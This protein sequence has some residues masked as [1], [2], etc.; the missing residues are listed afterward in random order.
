[1]VDIFVSYSS[2][3]LDRVLPLVAA[4]EAEGWNVWWDRELVTGDS[5]D[6]E[7]ENALEVA[8][9]IVVV[10]SQESINSRWVRAEAN[11]G[12]ERRI[13]IPVLIDPVRPPLVF[14]SSQTAN[15][16]GWPAESGQIEM[17]IAAINDLP[18]Q[19][20]KEFQPSASTVPTKP[21]IAVLPFTNLSG[22][23]ENEYFSDG[24]TE[25]ILNGLSRSREIIVKARTS[26]FQFKGQNVDVREIAQRLGVTH[27]VE[28]SVRR[29]GDQV[30]V[31]AQ[32]IDARRDDHVWS[33][34]YT[35][36]LT[37]VFA[38]QDE[39]AAS[40]LAA[41][42]LHLPS[43]RTQTM[44]VANIE[45]YSLYL[46]GKHFRN[47]QQF[48]NALAALEEAIRLEPNF[49]QVYLEVIRVHQLRFMYQQ[50]SSKE[51][52]MV[53]EAL[54]ARAKELDPNQPML[55]NGDV[56][57]CF[58]T[59]R[60]YQRALSEYD[61]IARK[62]PNEMLIIG[63]YALALR[64][65]GQMDLAIACQHQV[66]KL[67]PINP[68]AHSIL[69]SY[70]LNAGR[71]DEARER[72][73]LAESLGIRSPMQLAL[74]AAL[75]GDMTRL[76]MQLARDPINWAIPGT[77][78]LYRAVLEFARGNQKGV[79][80]I[81]SVATFETPILQGAS[82]SLCGDVKAAVKYYGD[83]LATTD[84]LAYMEVN[85]PFIR[86]LTPELYNHPSYQQMLAK[87]SLDEK[88]LAKLQVYLL[89]HTFH[90]SEQT[91]RD[92]ILT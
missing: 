54:T 21:A 84:K 74:I 76:E 45:A 65:I 52:N 1:M 36:D 7:I 44:Q 77:H 24:I 13:L 3:D 30:R 50:A 15:L 71:L 11:E 67:D 89:P 75:Q 41:L 64:I 80:D 5:F 28:G 29:Y 63:D 49:V 92:Q 48:D 79:Q 9:C 47:I 37:D 25:E 57:T 82:A 40:I 69:A 33:D 73:E 58:Y 43:T 17:V 81:V 18:S 12:L 55:L 78:R 85:G 46:K 56:N 72:L 27:I 31:T 4:L 38:V 39:I 8:S 62:F 2:V 35:R 90:Q 70:L 6:E 68:L 83:A 22:D 19:S 20:K 14:R 86:G 34:K 10:W 61:V 53:I 88:S 32:L 91:S 59:D 60:D 87:Y 66:L 23:I 42:N 16:I 51:V 26:S